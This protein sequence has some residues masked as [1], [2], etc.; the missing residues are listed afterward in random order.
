MI[1]SR[2]EA[3]CESKREEKVE[4]EKEGAVLGKA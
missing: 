1:G 3:D 4:V 2:N